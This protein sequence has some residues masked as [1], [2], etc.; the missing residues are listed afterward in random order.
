[1]SIHIHGPVSSLVRYVERTKKPNKRWLLLKPEMCLLGN[2][3]KLAYSES[4]MPLRHPHSWF[5]EL[6]NGTSL[7]YQIQIRLFIDFLLLVEQ[8]P[9][10]LPERMRSPFVFSWVRVDQSLVFC[11]VVCISLFVLFGLFW[12]VY[13]MSFDLWLLIAILLSSIFSYT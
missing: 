12:R 10:T 13:C 2:P 8:E 5:S 3:L 1:M 11:D 6:L 4:N 7:Y 9:L